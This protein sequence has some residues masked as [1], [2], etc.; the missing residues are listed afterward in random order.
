[1]PNEIE[2]IHVAGDSPELTQ[3]LGLFDLTR[4]AYRVKVALP[5]K[6]KGDHVYC[7]VYLHPDGS[8]EVH[9]MCPRCHGGGVGHMSRIHSSRKQ[10]DYDPS[11]R[12]A[13]GGELNVEPFMCTWELGEDRRMEFGLGLCR[14]VM[15][16][17]NSIA[18]D[19]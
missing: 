11:R 6:Y 2:E 8:R 16:I 18:K 15:V 9:W 7:E 3:K 12:V 14:L 17:D 13:V 5:T 10:I 4:N 19:A 1:M